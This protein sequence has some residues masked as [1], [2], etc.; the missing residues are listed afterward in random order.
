MTTSDIALERVEALLKID[1]GNGSVY[2][3]ISKVVESLATNK[4]GE[5][6]DKIET[7]SRHLKQA[8]FN[9]PA[10]PDENA[11]IVLDAAGEEKRKL[12]CS[13]A[14][15]LVR[16]PSDPASAPGVLGAV[17]NFMED[18]TMFEWAGVGFGK[19]ES[20]H[21]A[22]S[23]R[24]LA[25]ETPSLETL[26]FWGKILGTEGDF[27][28]AEGRLQAI[29]ETP[30]RPAMPDAA[31]FDVEPRGEGANA[32]SYWVSPGAGAPWVRLPAARA[33]HIAAAKKVKRLMTGDLDS[34]VFTMPFFPGSERHLLRA[35]IARI[36][37][38]CTLS[39]SGYYEINSEGDPP[40]VRLKDVLKETEEFSFPSHDD[41]SSQ[42]TWV[43]ASPILWGTGKTTWPD[44]E[45]LKA[46]YPDMGEDKEAVL[47]KQLKK[48]DTMKEKEEGGG[49]KALLESIEGDLKGDS[50][51]TS[52]A[53]SIKV[54]GEKGLYTVADATK[55]YRVTAVRS[56]IWPGAVTV[57]QGSRFAN[58]YIGYGLKYGTLVP[59][60]ESGEPLAGT[61]PYLPLLPEAV[62]EEP[63]ELLEHAEPNPEIQD[64]A[65]DKGSQD[66]EEGGDA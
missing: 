9:G 21:I 10:G 57:A 47:E 43:H 49:E 8:T 66:E 20:Y 52:P 27:Y 1:T 63:T 6:L 65:S 39:V 40:P 62:M 60:K 50:D 13:E 38:T 34:Q 56:L 46:A 16:P 48:F 29:S 15:K 42:G 32:F 11:D 23:L 12:W 22:M 25:A 5:A 31:E 37:A 59:K 30:E 17:Q 4:T 35:Q 24:K 18:A 55:S 64:A 51:E 26:R 33:S 58:V 36:T 28:V 44:L 53:W 14:L 19:Q 2:S 45:A 3:H 7:L 54:H 41:L 61:T